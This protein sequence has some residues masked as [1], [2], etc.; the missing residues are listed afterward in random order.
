MQLDREFAAEGGGEEGLAGLGELRGYVCQQRSRP[1]APRRQ[2][3]QPRHDPALLG[4]RG[5]RNLKLQQMC[6]P[7]VVDVNSS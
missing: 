3:F 4:E 1:A 2:R 5:E 6:R 7:E